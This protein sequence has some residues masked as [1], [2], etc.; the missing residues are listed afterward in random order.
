MYRKQNDNYRQFVDEMIA[1]SPQSYI[2]LRDLYDLFK[3]WFKE[4]LPGQ[5]LPVKNEVKEHFIKLWGEPI[6][7]RWKGYKVKDLN[8][9][10]DEGTAVIV[11]EDELIDY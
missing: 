4:G 10:V 8:E 1:P 7:N 9:E 2:N 3:V 11:N 6:N 5:Q